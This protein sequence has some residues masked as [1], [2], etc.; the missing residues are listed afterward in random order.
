MIY[1][2]RLILSVCILLCPYFALSA[3]KI[4]VFA[5]ISLKE[6][7]EDIAVNY[8]LK[9]SNKLTLVLAS[10]S[11]LAR[12]IEQD[13]PAD[14]FICA[15]T[16]WMNY[17]N[18]KNL[19]DKDSELILLNN[20]LVLIAPLDPNIINTDIPNEDKN[21][22]NHQ[23]INL[24]N[25]WGDMPKWNALLN[26]GRLAVG[27][28]NYVPAGMYAKTT[29]QALNIW[30]DLKSTLAPASNVRAALMLVESGEAALGIVYGSDIIASKKIKVI[31]LF[32]QKLY[33]AINYPLAIITGHETPA[34]RDFYDYLQ[35]DDAR[36]IFIKYGFK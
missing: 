2:K 14:I 3:Q 8:E 13:A 11:K 28:P 15:N 19:I 16:N 36:T 18:D 17:L 34:V 1:F 5:A 21:N 9:T 23:L 4:N 22:V 7:L 24:E 31:G 20:S 6:A 27:D 32:D 29:L 26:G 35:S 30:Q 25:N 10:S 12:Q 33:G